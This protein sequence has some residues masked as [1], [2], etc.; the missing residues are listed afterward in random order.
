MVCCAVARRR[1]NPEDKSGRR[2]EISELKTDNQSDR[3]TARSETSSTVMDRNQ[4]NEC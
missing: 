2:R 1:E 4:M 3:A